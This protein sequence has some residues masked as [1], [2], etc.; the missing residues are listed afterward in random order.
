MRWESKDH[1]R[2]LAGLSEWKY[3]FLTISSPVITGASRPL[4]NTILSGSSS[5]VPSLPCSLQRHHTREETRV[6]RLSSASHVPRV[7]GGSW[8]ACNSISTHVRCFGIFYHCIFEISQH[9]LN[10][11]FVPHF[12]VRQTCIY[13]RLTESIVFIYGVSDPCDSTAWW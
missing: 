9:R 2:P 13:A 6:L 11:V 7:K 4:R 3:Y 5:P 12:I 8:R 10:V 1:F